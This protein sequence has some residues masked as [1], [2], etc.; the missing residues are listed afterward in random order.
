M[1]SNELFLATEQIEQLCALL[2]ADPVLEVATWCEITPSP[3]RGRAGGGVIEVAFRPGV[4]D[5]SAREL[6]RGMV[7]IGL[8]ACE[9][10]TAT[11]YE[12]RGDLTEADLRKM[13]RGLLCNETV[14]HYSLEAINPHFGQNRAVDCLAALC[15]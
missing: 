9:V 14:E 6:A 8:P 1:P 2:L 13:A 4:T 5:V 12:L 3:I 7:E 11:R 10:A 15:A